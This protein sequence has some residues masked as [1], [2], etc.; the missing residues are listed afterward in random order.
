MKVAVINVVGYQKSTG[1]I[2]SIIEKNLNQR[3]HDVKVFYGREDKPLNEN[4]IKFNVFIDVVIHY[5]MQKITNKEGYYSYL[6]TKYLEKK[7]NRFN[8]DVFILLNLHGHYLNIPEFMKYIALKN[9]KVLYIMA[10]EYPYTACCTYASDCNFLQDGCTKCSKKL[11]NYKIMYDDKKNYNK[12]LDE[13]IRYLGVDYGLYRMRKSDIVYNKPAGLLY[14]PIETNFYYPVDYQMVARKYGIDT[15][16]ICFILVAPYSNKR[17]GVKFFLETAELLE[18]DNRFLFI[19]I[20]FDAKEIKIPS[21][22]IAIPFVRDQE[23]LRQLYS[24]GDLYIC[25]SL[26]D[27]MPNACLEA[28]SCGTPVLAFNVSGMAYM[29]K[30]PMISTI[31]DVSTNGIIEHIKKVQKKN[32]KIIQDCSN[33]AN[34]NFSVDSFIEKIEYHIYN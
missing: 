2:A 5:L 19:N 4:Y 31:D 14:P 33:Y 27:I 15:T 6:P 21:N 23:E 18:Q 7:L 30:E 28:L 10:D 20:G 25:T 17:K 29:R 3:N 24:M 8:P 12:L 13:N 16:K 26:Y 1:K 22:F 11:K 32:P 9:K 34:I